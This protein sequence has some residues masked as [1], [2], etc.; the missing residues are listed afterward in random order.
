MP[1]DVSVTCDNCGNNLAVSSNCEDYR[2]ALVNQPVPSAG[3]FVHSM[4][5]YPAIEK[6]AYFCGVECL[7]AWLD[8]H[9][10]AAKGP[11]HRGKLGARRYQREK[12]NDQ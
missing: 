4:L 11:Y 12:A 3:G 2:L 1:K 7:R 9:Y 6:D 5:A 8:K 10:P